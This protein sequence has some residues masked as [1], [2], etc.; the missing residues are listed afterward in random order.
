[1]VRAYV[2][3]PSSPRPQ[4][5]APRRPSTRKPAPPSKW[6]LFFDTETTIDASQSLR[7]GAYQLRCSAELV[8]HGLFYDAEGVT[9][10]EISFLTQVA[11][12]S[13][14]MLLT[15]AEFVDQVFY[16][17]GYDL[18]ATIVGMNLPFDISRLAI[19]HNSARGKMKGG[20]TFQLSSDPRRARVQIR[21]LN[22]KSAFIQFAAPP[23]QRTVRGSRRRN[24]NTAVRRGSFVDLRTIAAALFSRTFSLKSLADHLQTKSRKHEAEAHGAQLT[25]EYVEYAV[26][27]VAVTSECFEALSRRFDE[28]G[29]S[30]TH[31]GKV[32][33]EASIGKAYLREMGIKSL[34]VMQP[35][36][37][38]EMMGLIMSTY[39]GGRSEVRWR[40]SIKQVLYCD[41][42][43]M[44]P[45]VCTLMR[46]WKFVVAKGMTWSED[47]AG[48]QAFLDDVRID[49]LQQPE[50]WQRLHTII[51]IRPEDDIFP[52]RARYD[53]TSPTIGLN[54][55]SSDHPLWYNLADAI[56]SK[57]LT[58]RP[59]RILRAITFRPREP[60][61]DLR[62]VRIGGPT[63]PAID[64][65]VDDLY[66]R[67][68]D[69]RSEVKDR[70]RRACP[71]EKERLDAEQQALKTLANST[72]YG[73]FV[74]FNV[75]ELD[76]YEDRACFGPSGSAFSVRTR[77]SEEPGP[78]LNP[79]IATLITGAARLMLAIAEALAVDA[80]LDWAFCDTDSMAFARPD[81]AHPIEFFANARQ[82][83][84]WFE[85]LNPYEKPGPLLKIEDA[86]SVGSDPSKGLDT[87]YALC[88]S[89]KR[90]V[91]FNRRDDRSIVIRKASAHGLGHMM[92]PYSDEA[93]LSDFPTPRADVRDVERWQHD[94]WHRIIAAMLNGHA[95]EVDLD[96][97]PALKLPAMSR[98]GATTP[99]ILRWLARLIHGSVHERQAGVA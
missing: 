38:P 55:I 47:T 22:S 34:F 57:L 68:I 49:D 64:P 81:G 11:A 78:F 6:V 85:R 23:K 91:L 53:G 97:H 63:G 40:R 69:L 42:L 14:A 93:A 59:P 48:T 8:E 96:Y 36:F 45:T 32:Q 52:L 90:Y 99:P 20:F 12:R 92:A 82:I 16:G 37:P 26:Q 80:G 19:R 88:I 71:E 1:M 35:D 7:F 95:D 60:Q 98:Y 84:G 18:R 56:S 4:G 27:D 10:D 76:S 31:I 86:N 66:R 17:K 13:N 83:V 74:E 41:F 67:L 43:S 65:L 54:R 29:L 51:Q 25:S 79:L 72:S 87:L 94:L 58:G 28:H 73:I 46:L 39:F 77:K 30:G 33:S 44:Y 75:S 62:P 61:D 50:T 2:P 3:T 70:I 24:I 9:L 15:R 21:H 5:G 89:S